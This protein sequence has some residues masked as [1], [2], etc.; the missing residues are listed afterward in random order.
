[1]KP[2]NLRE[3]E[4][5][6]ILD[7]E[8]A[9]IYRKIQPQPN[10]WRGGSSFFE[11]QDR[12]SGTV[13]HA[14]KEAICILAERCPNGTVGDRL[15]VREAAYIAPHNYFAAHDCNYIDHQGRP[16][17]VGYKAS[18]CG[19]AV[20]CAEEYNVKRTSPG[21][22]PRWASRLTAELTRV[23]VEKR[24]GEWQWALDLSKCKSWAA[25]AK[26]EGSS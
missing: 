9:T 3:H 23:T 17:V 1:M 21:K 14:P 13:I 22:M 12:V 19:D 25:I 8:T 20:R 7:N 6:E 15:W 2:I 4:V 24:G 26:A 5:R 11:W 10:T 16:R 18:M